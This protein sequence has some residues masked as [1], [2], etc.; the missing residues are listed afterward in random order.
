MAAG[1]DL[2]IVLPC[3]NERGTLPAVLDALKADQQ[4]AEALFVVADGGSTDG[5]R[6]WVEAQ[7]QQDG[8]I[9]LLHNPLRRQSAGVNLAV[10]TF[11]G[12]RD[13]LLRIDA[14]AAYPLDF[15]T[16]LRSAASTT[17]ATSVVTP[18][19]T[20][21]LAC[22]QRAVA[23]AQ[24]SRL[25]TGGAAHRAAGRGGWVDHGHHALM[26]LPAFKA[27]G[28]YDENFL[29]N[30]D[31]ELDQRLT[32][33]GG[34][35]WLAEEAAITYFPRRT[36]SSLFVQYLRYGAGRAQ[37][38]LLHRSR[39]RLRQL[40]PTL[41]LP[42]LLGLCLALWTPLLAGP[43]L[44]WGSLCLGYGVVLAVK[45]RRPCV[46]LAGPA[47][48]LM[49]SAWSLGFWRTLLGPRRPPP[50]WRSLIQSQ[51]PPSREFAEDPDVQGSAH[52]RPVAAAGER[53]RE[54]RGA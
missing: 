20:E 12:G 40:L 32:R 39:L 44:G 15:V 38:L 23:A 45:A 52:Q 49:H 24:N 48:M 25:G 21:G 31:A 43:A 11:G 33:A 17:G 46:L 27:V 26:L 37:T 54:P 13:W 35:I 19:H 22:F 4:T 53:G 47:A 8:R 14:H 3:L 1:S 34:R 18:M 7:S 6:D 41:V 2:L 30:E 51:V 28:G 36:P 9:M 42:A 5:T 10:E 16:R 50:R 29:A